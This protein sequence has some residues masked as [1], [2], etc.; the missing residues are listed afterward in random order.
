[1]DPG[2]PE[3]KPLREAGP[4]RTYL[5]PTNDEEPQGGPRKAVAC[6]KLWA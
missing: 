1:M 5:V 6:R 4:R 3:E 2:G